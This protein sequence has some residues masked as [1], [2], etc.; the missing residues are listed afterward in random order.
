[1]G[2]QDIERL[3]PVYRACTDFCK[4]A[5]LP[6]RFKE[7]LGDFET[8]IGFTEDGDEFGNLLLTL[9]HPP[10][11]KNWNKAETIICPDILDYQH[12]IIIEFE[13]ETGPRKAGEK[14]A[15]KG[16]GHEGDLD[17][18]RDSRRNEFY[19]LAG[20]KVFRLWESTFKN[21]NWKAKLFEF[22]I[23]CWNKSLEASKN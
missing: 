9:Y 23:D 17:T 22:L 10:Y 16:H 7:D 20:F 19:Q 12:K 1:M 15:R 13:E 8:A 4:L 21:E 11:S 6:F 2:E 18:K 14:Y 5:E 3:Y